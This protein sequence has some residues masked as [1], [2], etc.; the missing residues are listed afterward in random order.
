MS[1]ALGAQKMPFIV[2]VIGLLAGALVCI[3]VI[4]T[5]LAAG[6]FQ[7][8]NLQQANSA[9]TRQQEQLQQQVASEQAPATI[10]QRARQLGMKPATALRFI[11]LRTGRVVTGAPAGGAAGAR[12]PG[13]TP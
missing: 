11:D 4:S 1:A 13:N 2:L 6:A 8:S 12:A 3:L 10:A 5:T 9:L 7:I